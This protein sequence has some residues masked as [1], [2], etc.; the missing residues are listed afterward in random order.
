MSAPS[1]PDAH[2][3]LRRAVATDLEAL[4]RLWVAL[5]EHH[6]ARDPQYA[7]RPGAAGRVR[8]ILRRELRRADRAAFVADAAGA[9]IGYAL[10][11][12]DEAPDF[13]A[14]GPRAA[15]DDLYVAPEARRR[16]IGAALAAAASGWARERGASHVEVRV[17]AA[18]PEGQA[19]WRAQGYAA[20]VDVLQHRL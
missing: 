19:F 4:T 10:V 7:L 9:L 20:Y 8:E 16:G 2:P 15:I 13:V 17:A 12:V 6:A 1:P 14:E 18:N 3:E 11:R 5:G